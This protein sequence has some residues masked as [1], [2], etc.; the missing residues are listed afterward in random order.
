MSVP[1]V[2]VYIG[3]GSNLE[4]PAR[5]VAAALIELAGLPHS[6]L[7]AQSRLYQSRP[8][9]PQ[10]QPDFVN[11]AAALETT[12]APL[13]LLHAVQVLEA[14]HGRNR[15][16]ERHWGPRTL[17][18]DILLYGDLRLHTEELTLPHP[19]LHERSFV[20][21]PLAELAPE[22]MIPGRGRVRTLRDQCRQPPLEL[23]AGPSHG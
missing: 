8:L 5:Q 23:S 4:Q 16:A 7:L 3:I 19:R 21:Y 14:R 9:G 13:V 6:R 18:L 17:D 12:L 22:L 11:A 10:D 15:A 1:A 2:K 20:L